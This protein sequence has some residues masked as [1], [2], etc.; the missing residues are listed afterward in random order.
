MPHAQNAPPPPPLCL[1]AKPI[2]CRIQIDAVFKIIAGNVRRPHFTS[3]GRSSSPPASRSNPRGRRTTWAP[4]WLSRRGAARLMLISTEKTQQ[5]YAPS[6][7]LRKFVDAFLRSRQRAV[8]IF[9]ESCALASAWCSFCLRGS[10]RRSFCFA[11]WRSRLRGVLVLKMQ[12]S[13]ARGARF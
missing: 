10:I 6:E 8:R 1:C 2:P 3:P 13:P 7:A 5:F 11:K 9:F 4:L 12:L